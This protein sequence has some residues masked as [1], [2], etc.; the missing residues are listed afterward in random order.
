[1]NDM[2][3]PQVEPKSA[4][5]PARAKP[6]A[7]ITLTERAAARVR[8]LIAKASK[9]VLG[10]RVGVNAKGCSG[11]S[12]VVEYAEEQRKFEDVVDQHGVKLF[13][14]PTAVMYL[15]G[16]ELDYREDKLE[17][18]FVFTNPNEKGRCGCGESFT[19]GERREG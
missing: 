4:G 19:I 6:P 12:Y 11:M 13:I 15:L 17:S 9:P 18:G 5:Q 8:A 14:D 3:P 10:L 1:M 7:A 2:T 16:S